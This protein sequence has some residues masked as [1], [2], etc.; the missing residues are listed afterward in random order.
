MS[1]NFKLEIDYG[2]GSV[3]FQKILCFVEL[4]SLNL[5]AGRKYACCQSCGHGEMKE[6]LRNNYICC[7]GSYIFSTIH[8]L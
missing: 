2:I 5:L 4:N 7:G 1:K 3:N 8:R 6:V